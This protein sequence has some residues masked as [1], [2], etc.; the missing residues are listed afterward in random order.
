M[1]SLDSALSVI[2]SWA[3][4]GVGGGAGFY[5]VKWFFEWLGGRVDKREAAAEKVSELNDATT[6]R[7]IE[8]LEARLDSLTT[9]LDHVEGELIQCRAQHATCE[10]ELARLKGIIQGL[11][12]A[13]QQAANIV[14][15]ERTADRHVEQIVRKIGE[16][17][18]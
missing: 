7:L 16:A 14:A 17:K 1:P 6:R 4:A 13:K 11:G 3:A 10:A 2:P 5:F 12:D 8:K 15:A 18:T 9:R